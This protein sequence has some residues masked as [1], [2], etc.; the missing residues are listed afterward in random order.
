VYNVGTGRAASIAELLA[1]VQRL[2][3]KPITVET[4]PAWPNDIQNICADM[5]LLERELGFQA[6]VGFEQGLRQTIEHF[7]RTP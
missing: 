7:A 5:S 6:R 2:A 1:L 4:H 3:P